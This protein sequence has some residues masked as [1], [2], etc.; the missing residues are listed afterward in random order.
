[1]IDDGTDIVHGTKENFV[2]GC[3]IGILLSIGIVAMLYWMYETFLL[4]VGHL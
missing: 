4:S 2:R 3:L 1:M